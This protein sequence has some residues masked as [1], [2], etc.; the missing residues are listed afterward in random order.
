MAAS[1]SP[2]SSDSGSG[3]R[4]A[5]QP[6]LQSS[7]AGYLDVGC[8]LGVGIWRSER[9]PVDASASAT[10]AVEAV[11]GAWR[12]RRDAVASP[13]EVRQPHEDPRQ[14]VPDDVDDLL[15]GSPG[16]LEHEVVR[17]ATLDLSNALIDESDLGGLE[18]GLAWGSPLGGAAFAAG[19]ERRPAGI[20]AGNVVVFV[21]SDLDRLIMVRVFAAR[22]VPAI[23]A[24]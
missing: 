12:L 23:V 6:N 3:Q 24:D 5:L 9:G 2:I 7:R 18:R 8:W 4:S 13:Q 22:R 11:P 16:W 21:F 15:H 20:V 10:F 17:N 1:R 14:G 19:T